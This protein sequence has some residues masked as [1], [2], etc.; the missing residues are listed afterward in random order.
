MKA[1]K[2]KR[3]SLRSFLRRGLV[4]LSLFAL[5]FASCGE[6]GGGDDTPP[7]VPPPPPP[8]PVVKSI[9]IIQ[10]P[11][12]A[13]FQGLP[14]VLTGLIA[15][16]E[17]DD[18]RKE[19]T[20]DTS[21]FN[22][23][24]GYC[25][26][27]WNYSATAGAGVNTVPYDKLQLYYKGQTAVSQQLLIN[28]I[29]AA[30]KIEITQASSVAWFSDQRPDFTGL[31]YNVIFDGYA[32][33][34]SYKR[35]ALPMTAAYPKTDYKEVVDKKKL[36]VFVGPYDSS[37]YTAANIMGVTSGG[38]YSG[39][40]VKTDFYLANYYQ[41]K[42]IEFKGMDDAIFYDDDVTTFFT[43]AAGTTIDATN[44]YAQLKKYNVK[45]EVSY[46]GTDVT[47]SLTMDDFIANSIYYRN[48]TGLASGGN[49]SAYMLNAIVAATDPL[50]VD[51]TGNT[52]ILRVDPDDEET[53][54]IYLDY[55]PLRY[56]SSASQTIVPVS[57]SLYT[58]QQELRR[59]EGPGERFIW[60]SDN[61]RT[62][63]TDE[64]NDI[65]TKWSLQG[66]YMKGRQTSYKAITLTPQMFYD[67]YAGTSYG[68]NSLTTG[69]NSYRTYSGRVFF[70]NSSDVGGRWGL[71]SAADGSVSMKLKANQIG[72]D[73]PLPVYYRGGYLVDED[74]SV[75]VNLVGGK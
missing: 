70:P 50:V 42:A 27:A 40:W 61:P 31:T 14:P 34:G 2:E 47:K 45:F 38:Q 69:I 53:W 58:F 55:A 18:G 36:T 11:T 20:S 13:S 3:V 5:V 23:A 68:W 64:L 1:L 63:N 29:Y 65:K 51:P 60:A 72:R 32:G 25:D 33:V 35:E 28:R 54:R 73:F 12:G 15:E 24:P 67:G 56:N 46:T 74:E 62:M 71:Y 19:V 21:L 44:V 10:Q 48:L 39:S 66:Q 57:L 41:V 52:S 22:T 75:V 9:T 6:S 17:W 49:N 26:T 59:V 43:S 30:T 4:I 7:D 37:A 16:I 8:A